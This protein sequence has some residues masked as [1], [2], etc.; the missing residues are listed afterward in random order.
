[1]KV[2]LSNVV[3]LST[4][5]GAGPTHAWTVN[6]TVSIQ[7]AVAYGTTMS[8]SNVLE[9]PFVDRLWVRAH[10]YEEGILQDLDSKFCNRIYIPG[11]VP[12]PTHLSCNETSEDYF[13]TLTCFYCAKGDAGAW[14]VVGVFQGTV[15]GAQD[16]IIYGAWW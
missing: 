12:I 5:L 16:C 7:F 15:H 14:N 10:I 13:L 2:L 4:L 9:A 11:P 3:L 1:M 6:N 8:S